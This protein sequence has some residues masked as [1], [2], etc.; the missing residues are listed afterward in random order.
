[1]K[2]VRLVAFLLVFVIAF[3]AWTPAPVLASA[4]TGG[5]YSTKAPLVSLTVI[6]R[7]Y[8]ALQ[9]TLEGGSGGSY[10]F[11]A[12]QG[13]TTYQIVPGKYTYTV[14]FAPNSPCIGG[15]PSR[16]YKPYLV[17]TRRF[18]NLKNTLGPYSACTL[19]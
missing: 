10:S 4:E 5:A 19:G 3:S 15:W 1:M 6:N 17:K 8:G 2:T 7:T 13:K 18:T 16:G 12:G 14:R 9:V 11:Y